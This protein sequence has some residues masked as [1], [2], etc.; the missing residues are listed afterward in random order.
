MRKRRVHGSVSD[1]FIKLQLIGRF[2]F[3]RSLTVLV[4]DGVS[5]ILQHQQESEDD[6][7]GKN[8][9][10]GRYG[11][12]GAGGCNLEHSFKGVADEFAP[13]FTGG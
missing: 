2:L 9:D 5:S 12:V 8:A 10:D 1:G 6:F 7:G 11:G 3:D 13:F 4:P